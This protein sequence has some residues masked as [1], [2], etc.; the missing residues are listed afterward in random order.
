[1]ADQGIGDGDAG[2]FL[3]LEA[4]C[5]DDDEDTENENNNCSDA[6]DLIDNAS[7]SSGNHLAWYQTIQKQAGEE[8]LLN[9]K[10][11]LR[12]SP[13]ADVGQAP[14]KRRPLAPRKLDFNSVENEALACSPRSSLCQVPMGTPGNGG[15]VGTQS[16]S[17]RGKENGG[18]LHLQILKAK[19]AS[20]CRLA[21][22]KEV[23]VAAY[24]DLTR[25][26]KHDKT[27]TV[28]WVAAIF[29]VRDTLVAASQELLQKD[30]IFF[31]VTCRPHEKG[32]MACYL[33]QF[34]V[35]KS[36]D[37]VKNLLGS[38]LNVSG[39][40]MLLQPPKINGTCAALFWY[41]LAMS[42]TTF[43]WGP[44]PTWIVQQ[45]LISENT[46]DN[47]KFSFSEMVQWAYD[48]CIYEE[49]RIAYEYALLAA[50]EANAKAW[51]NCNNQA[52]IVKDVSC[53]VRYYQRAETAS[54]TMS[55]YVNRQ[56][57]RAKGQGSW[58]NIMN[59]LKHQNIEPISFIN[60]LNPWL[61]GIPKRN[62]IVIIGQPNTGKSL[63]TNSL[64]QF[65]QGKVLS[66]AMHKTHFWL[67]PLTEARV[68]LI[69]D[70]TVPCLKYF[71]MYLRN[72]LDGYDVCIDRKHKSSVQIKCPPIMLTTNVD[73]HTDDRFCYL[74]SR[75]VSFYFDQPCPMDEENRPLFK[76]TDGDWD[77]FFRRL[78]HRL[79]LS[80]QEE[81]EEDGSCRAFTCSTGG[82][83]G[84]P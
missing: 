24:G 64:M 59:F 10:R 6:E 15:G 54:L 60:A 5:S 41:K 18:G 70:A 77:S 81:E 46:A 66:F 57:Q 23:F 8:Q 74:R 79:D 28:S 49:S 68:A 72:F 31:Q 76:F 65:L 34:K 47:C 37:T 17:G 56:C 51:L 83:N 75:M 13:V 36:R 44:T 84:L 39:E 63:F 1:M 7:V 45:T 9:L 50:T 53:M 3:L 38:M 61:K 80:D 62:C 29:G 58:M 32:T 35:S 20:A 11:K 67:S 82:T 42:S 30:C 69:D 73:I 26:Y 27:T 33:L 71:D 22:F 2:G 12:L 52:K 55:A 14:G 25:V 40:Q 4:E 43:T 16:G 78:W 19:N 21:L 48:N